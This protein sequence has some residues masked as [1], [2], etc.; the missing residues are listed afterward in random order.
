VTPALQFF[1]GGTP[2]TIRRTGWA[3]DDRFIGSVNSGNV[4]E[5]FQCARAAE[6]DG[7]KVMHVDF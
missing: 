6:N 4:T 1:L 2:L 3:D 7:N 5:L